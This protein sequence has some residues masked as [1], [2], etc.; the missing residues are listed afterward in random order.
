MSNNSRRDT[1]TVVVV[2]VEIME[3]WPTGVASPLAGIGE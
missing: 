3:C 2:V 1:R